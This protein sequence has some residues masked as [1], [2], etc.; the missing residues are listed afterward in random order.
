MRRTL[1]FAVLTVAA[2]AATAG[3]AAADVDYVDAG[4]GPGNSFDGEYAVL[5]ANNQLAQDGNG[6][7]VAFFV[8]FRCDDGER[9]GFVF[10]ARQD[11]EETRGDG[12]AARN[13]TGDTQHF[14]AVAE[15]FRGPNFDTDDGALE[16]EV[17]GATDLN[18]R[19]LTDAE[20]D[21]AVLYPLD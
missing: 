20:T 12:F 14:V 4:E 8:E 21:R 15:R 16:V 6:P 9:I 2:L 3:V 17:V 10:Q 5:E 13:C 19:N 18:E 1:L 7:K 11:D